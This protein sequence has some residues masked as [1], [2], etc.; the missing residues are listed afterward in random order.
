[1]TKAKR[2]DR[3]LHFTPRSVAA[4]ESGSKP[5][6]WRDAPDP[7]RPKEK[8]TR[9]L[10]LRVEVSGRMTW[11]CRYSFNGQDRR[12]TLGTFPA[13]TIGA[14]RRG[15]LEITGQTQGKHGTDPMAERTKAREG[16]TVAVAVQSW[17]AD[18][19][20]GPAARWKGGLTGG[21]SRSFMGHIR[22]LKAKEG[23]KRLTEL[24]PKDVEAFVS[25]PETPAT[26]NR[27]LTAFRLFVKWARRKQLMESDPSAQLPKER[28][29]ER[30]RVLSDDELK[31]LIVGF[32]ATR[33]GR[34]VRMLAL[35]GLRRGEVLGCRWAWIDTKA[36]VMEI[37]SAHEKTGA[38]RGEA[39]RVALS[40]AAVALLAE[41]R[42]Q[43]LRHG[44]S[45]FVFGTPA[46]RPHPDCLKPILYALKRRRPNGQPAS[47]AQAGEAAP[48]AAPRRPH[49]S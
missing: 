19:K 43:H 6:E 9:G 21:T 46:G 11:V 23:T 33:Y 12:F 8:W 10:V 18:K 44:R 13:K 22:A 20:L 30:R 32:D 49:G 45:A 14:A 17:L 1:M 2:E 38:A 34:A 28:E 26:R 4:L 39:R 16:G 31:A 47:T 24:T 3:Q 5:V 15:A 41:Q 48:E 42:E 40:A 35:T 7:E 36:G 27:R 29:A 37:P 25:K